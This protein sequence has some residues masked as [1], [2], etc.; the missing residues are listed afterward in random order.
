MSLSN[1]TVNP[2]PALVADPD[3]AHAALSPLRRRILEELDDPA[4]ATEVAHRLGLAR[5]KVNYHMGVLA[6][7][8]IVELAEERPRRG[9]TE[10]IYR[11]PD[12]LVIAPDILATKDRWAKQAVVA[13]AGDAIR[14]TATAEP[15]PT[16]ALVTDVTFATPADL[17][18]FLDDVATLAA[19]HGRKDHGLPIRISLLA[20]PPPDRGDDR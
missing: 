7:H 5:Q 12:A 18:A 15:G 8:G 3:A 11:R 10:R 20:H 4:S 19:R 2:V 9:F 17:R 6:R 16:A 1:S 13:A 14:A